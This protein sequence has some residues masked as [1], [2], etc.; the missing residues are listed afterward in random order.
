MERIPTFVF[1]FSF[2]FFLGFSEVFAAPVIEKIDVDSIRLLMK[3][4][5]GDHGIKALGSSATLIQILIRI[6]QSRGADQ[7]FQRQK[8]WVRLGIISLLTF[9]ITPVGL[10]TI[11]GLPLAA[12]LLHTATLNAFMVFLDQIL[13][14]APGK[15]D[16]TS[17]KP[18]IHSSSGKNDKD[19]RSTQSGQG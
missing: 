7:F 8:P 5:G 13:K 4:L 18:S 17:R 2:M 9:A 16:D 12:A 14:H 3:S 15:K 1:F 19:G 11:S 6:L 10:V